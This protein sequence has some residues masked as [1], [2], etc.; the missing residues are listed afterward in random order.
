VIEFTLL[1]GLLELQLHCRFFSIQPLPKK[2]FPIFVLA[3]ISAGLLAC[4]SGGDST[5]TATGEPAASTESTTAAEELPL[6]DDAAGDEHVRLAADPEIPNAF[7]ISEASASPGKDTIEFVNPTHVVHDLAIETPGGKKIAQTKK[8]GY[9]RTSTEAVL[10]ANVVY[11]AYCTLH[12]K[13]G[14]IGHITV[15]PQAPGQ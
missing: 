3:L 15:F 10:K 1:Q 11:V 4:G 5:G 12:R 14:M 7:H 6:L 13:D 8:I 9:G 2:A